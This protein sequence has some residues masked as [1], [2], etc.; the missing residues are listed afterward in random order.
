MDNF[1]HN[2]KSPYVN[3]DTYLDI[4]TYKTVYPYAYMNAWD[5][6]NET[7]LPTT[8]YL[9][10]KLYN[11]HTSEDDYERAKLVWNTFNLQCG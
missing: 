6:F 10:S 1:K 7:G 4:L 5:K 3:D 8:E 9:Y 11:E 2:G